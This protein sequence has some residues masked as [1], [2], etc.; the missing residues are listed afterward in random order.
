MISPGAAAAQPVQAPPRIAIVYDCLYPHTIGGCERWYRAVAARLAAR[1]RVTYLTRRQ[2]DPDQGPDAPRGV[3]VIGLDGGRQ[4]Y[5]ASG[6]RRIMPPLRFG[7][8]V[9]IHLL[10][11]RDRYDIVHTCSFPYFPLLSASL[12]RAVGG[13]AVVTDWVEVWPRDYWRNYL[14]AIGGAAGMAVQRLCIWLTR[15]SFTLSDLAAAMLR[16]QGYRGDPVVLKGIYDGP[17]LPAPTQL[18]REPMVVFAGRHIREKQVTVIPRAIALARRQIPDLKAV[19]FGDGPERPRVLSEIAR[20]QMQDAVRCP[21]FAPWDEVD[22]ALSNA[23][24]LL[25]PSR[26]EGYG[27]VVVEAAVRGTPSIVVRGSD[28]AATSL[29]ADGVNGFVAS[30]AEPAALAEAIIRVHAAGPALVHSTYQ[31]CLEHAQELSVDS[32][33]A[34]IEQV[35]RSLIDSKRQAHGRYA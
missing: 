15:T 13:P 22:S 27:L 29:V 18:Q 17:I 25:L 19:I 28:N 23:M 1:H 10:R 12:A 20:F 4:L 3:E 8:A 30:S 32:S 6:R 16:E 7:L 5:T 2:W 11:N 33:V 24:C 34:R 31:W 9:L 21:G 26:R 14:G 35:Y